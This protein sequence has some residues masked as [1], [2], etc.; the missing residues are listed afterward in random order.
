MR[1]LKWLVTS[2]DKRVSAEI[3]MGSQLYADGEEAGKMMAFNRLR[4]I[5]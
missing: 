5:D 1:L 4:F 3:T 2:W